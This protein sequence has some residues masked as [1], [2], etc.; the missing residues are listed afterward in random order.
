MGEKGERAFLGGWQE[1]RV[2]GTG[3]AFWHISPQL[4]RNGTAWTLL[5]R[6]LP[7]ASAAND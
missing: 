5:K 7:N 1:Q 2:S 6:V 3:M 4:I